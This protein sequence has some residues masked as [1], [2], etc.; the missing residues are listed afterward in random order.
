MSQQLTIYAVLAIKLV[1]IFI[2]CCFTLSI[3]YGILYL[4]LLFALHSYYKFVTCSQGKIARKS[5]IQWIVFW[6]IALAHAYYHQ[7]SMID[8]SRDNLEDIIFHLL[9]NL[10]AFWICID[11][12]KHRNN[13]NNSNNTNKNNHLILVKY[14]YIL[15]YVAVFDMII[16]LIAVSI[17]YNFS[18]KLLIGATNGISAFYILI[19]FWN[20]YIAEMQTI[21]DN[22][23]IYCISEK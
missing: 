6:F 8:P 7:F 14:C 13:D 23:M 18:L 15:L 12:D 19:A 9:I 20:D 1:T 17:G 16:Y 21:R 10:N 22:D 2:C 4:S 3:G 11:N 5:K